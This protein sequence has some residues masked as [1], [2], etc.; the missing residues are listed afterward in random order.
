MG[1]RIGQ[2]A[3]AGLV[4]RRSAPLRANYVSK[5]AGGACG[6]DIIPLSTRLSSYPLRYLFIWREASHRAAHGRFYRAIGNLREFE[7]RNLNR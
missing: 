1:C 6:T 3:S 7:W 2:G 4:P 5:N